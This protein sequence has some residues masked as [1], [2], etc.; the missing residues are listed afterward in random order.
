[1]ILSPAERSYLYDSLAQSPPIRPDSRSDHQFRPLEAKTA[2]L[3][4][5][6]GSARIRLMDGSECIISVKAKVVLASQESSLIECDIDIAGFRD[7]SNFV[8]NLKFYLTNLLLHNF[9]VRYLKLTSR[10]AFKLFLDCIVVSHSSYPL[11]LISLTSYLAL[12]TTRLPLLVSDVNDEEIAEQPTFSDDWD[13]A[14]YIDDY[15]K[16]GE[17]F[18]PPIFITLGVIG[19]NLIIDPSTEE[20]QVL[21]NGLIISFYNNNVITPISNIN[22]ATNSNNSNFKGLNRTLITKG[23]ALGNKYCPAIISALNTLIEQDDEEGTIF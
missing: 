10:Y 2:F 1:M 3:P 4:G 9:P 21:E 14:K 5:S 13:N 12:K 16:E 8:S 6:N 23:I 11:S 19:P 7:D 18:E 20:E 15:L 17:S 22:L